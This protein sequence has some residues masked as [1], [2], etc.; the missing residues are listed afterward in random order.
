[1]SSRSP[2]TPYI[3]CRSSLAARHVG[4]EVE[5]VARLP[6]EAQGVEAPQRERGVADPRVAV[7]PV[8][9]AARG[10][11]QRGGGRG[12]RPP[13][14]ARRSGPSGSART[15]PGTSATGGPGSGRAPASAASG[16]RS[17]PAA[18][19]RRRSARRLSLPPG[20]G[21]E[22][23]LALLDQRAGDGARTL[24]ADV[25]VARERQRELSVTAAHAPGGSPTPCTP[26]GRSSAVVEDGLAV[27]RELHLAVHAAH[28]PQQ[29]VLGVVIGGSPSLGA[30]ALLLVAP[31]ARS[32][33]RRGRSPS[34]SACPSWS[35]GPSCRAGSGGRPERSRPPGR[36]GSRPASR[37]RM[38]PKTLGESMRG[39]HSHS[40]LP[41]GATRAVASQSDRKA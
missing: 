13:R 2:P 28:R 12:D 19:T 31:R 29:D 21:A 40:T 6:V 16:G 23:R 26:T 24:E 14:S 10:L 8:A 34:R 27:E 39:R 17:R 41:L 7:V 11:R 37:S 33:A 38:A 25:D 30:G 4:D 20:Q 35:R 22:A 15:A 32:A 18:C 36:S 5:E 3:T 1:M 9:L